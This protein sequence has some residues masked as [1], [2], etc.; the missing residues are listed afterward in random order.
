MLDPVD[1]PHF[2]DTTGAKRWTQTYQQD[3]AVEDGP[4]HNTTHLTRRRKTG[5]KEV[6]PLDWY[7]SVPPIGLDLTLDHFNVGTAHKSKLMCDRCK[8]AW[9]LRRQTANLALQSGYY[10]KWPP[11]RD[12]VH[13]RSEGPE[14]VDYCFSSSHQMQCLSMLLNTCHC[15]SLIH[16]TK[17]PSAIR[18][19]SCQYLSVIH[20]VKKPSAMGIFLLDWFPSSTNAR[21]PPENQ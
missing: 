14:Q 12:Q 3:I 6:S 1:I 5:G 10:L 21:R 7:L 15:L 18:F 13:T 8:N 20:P 4:W 17:K 19:Y 2:G 11:T 9:S 16:Q